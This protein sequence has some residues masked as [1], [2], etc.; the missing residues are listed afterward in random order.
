MWWLVFPKVTKM[1]I[2]LDTYTLPSRHFGD[3]HGWKSRL[4]IVIW[5]CGRWK[6]R[7]CLLGTCFSPLAFLE[8]RMNG[9]LS[10]LL[11]T[12]VTWNLINTVEWLL[13]LYIYLY[14]RGYSTKFL[15]FTCVFEKGELS[16]WITLDLNWFIIKNRKS[17]K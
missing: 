9:L 12:I 1:F 4:S 15:L 16:C 6:S 3:H 2:H 5:D 8:N 11:Y 10:L 13:L 14:H 7:P 17:Q